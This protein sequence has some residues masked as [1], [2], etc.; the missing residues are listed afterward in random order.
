MKFREY[1]SRR[2]GVAIQNEWDWLN[3][4][5]DTAK[6]V[7]GNITGTGRGKVPSDFK[8]KLNMAKDPRQGLFGGQNNQ[9]QNQ[10]GQQNQQQGQKQGGLDPKIVKALEGIDR[11]NNNLV[12]LANSDDNSPLG[13]QL[14]KMRKLANELSTEYRVLVYMAGTAS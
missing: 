11:I 8:Q 3:K 13:Q 9:Q 12:F 1:L 14:T 5:V 4:A 6:N 7:F 10:Q 2:D